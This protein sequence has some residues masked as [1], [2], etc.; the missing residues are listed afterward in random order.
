M[1]WGGL[2]LRFHSKCSKFG[3]V[4]HLGLTILGRKKKLGVT[5][6]GTVFLAIENVKN[7]IL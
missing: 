1:A 6:K 2:C 4:L 7:G 5:V 3:T